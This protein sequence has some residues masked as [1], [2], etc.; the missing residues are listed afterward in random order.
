MEVMGK[1][2]YIIINFISKNKQYKV[3]S[4]GEVEPSKFNF[5]ESWLKNLPIS[6]METGLPD[7]YLDSNNKKTNAYYLIR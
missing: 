7:N 3:F 2:V 5:Y 6:S 4:I 1:V